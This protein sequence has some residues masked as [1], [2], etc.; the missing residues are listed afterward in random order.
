M[1]LQPPPDAAV[2]KYETRVRTTS[3]SDNQ[4]IEA[5]DKT[6]SV[7]IQPEVSVLP[8][9]VLILTLIGVV[10]GIVVFGVRLARR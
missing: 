5:E 3:F 7:E 6:V 2:G 8:S 1:R 10:L 9:L 4:P